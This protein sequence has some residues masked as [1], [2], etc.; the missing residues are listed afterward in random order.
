MVSASQKQRDNKYLQKSEKKHNEPNQTK[1][2][3][4]VCFKNC[5]ENRNKLQNGTI[6]VL[7]ETECLIK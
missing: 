1:I 2:K 7:R 5:T 6:N 4:I 3:E